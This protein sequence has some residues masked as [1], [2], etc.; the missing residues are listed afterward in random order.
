MTGSPDRQATLPKLP[1]RPTACRTRLLLFS[2][3]LQASV[4]AYTDHSLTFSTGQLTVMMLVF[5][6]VTLLASQLGSL[7]FQSC[8]LISLCPSGHGWMPHSMPTMMANSLFRPQTPGLHHH[9]GL[10]GMGHSQSMAHLSSDLLSHTLQ[11]Q[12][13]QHFMQHDSPMLAALTAQL[14]ASSPSPLELSSREG[15]TPFGEHAAPMGQYGGDDMS[16]DMGLMDGDML[17]MLLK[18][19]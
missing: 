8:H 2:P 19:E 11:A 17:E 9:L 6:S 13:D 16:Q 3:S 4:S 10:P 12:R 1:F 14:Q 5:D 18:P 15:L 7:P